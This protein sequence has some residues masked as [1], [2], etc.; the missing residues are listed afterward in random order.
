M[1][2]GSGFR[3]YVQHRQNT[4]AFE[5][6]C[7]SILIIRQAGTLTLKP[8]GQVHLYT[9]IG[10]LRQMPWFWHGA[11]K[12]GLHLAKTRGSTSPAH[13]E[14]DAMKTKGNE[15]KKNNTPL[16]LSV[17]IFPITVDSHRMPLHVLSL[18]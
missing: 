12:Q 2:L 6:F 7:T 9:S 5:D 4:D 10:S 18:P 1:P 15:N 17:L 3:S 16:N 14:R 8:S 13:K 11:D